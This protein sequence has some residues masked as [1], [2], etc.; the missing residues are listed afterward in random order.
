M[1]IRHPRLELW[2]HM[3]TQERLRPHQPT[4]IM[5]HTHGPLRS[6]I[7]S[8]P[9]CSEHGLVLQIR[10]HDHN[11]RGRLCL[12]AK[13]T[14]PGHVL[15]GHEG[16]VCDDDHVEVPIRNEHAIR[17]F[18]DLGEDVLDWIRR[19]VAFAFGAAVVVAA[20]FN[21][22]DEDGVVGAFAPGDVRGRMDGGFDVGAVEVGGSAVGSVDELGGEGEDVPE[23]RALLVHFV[24]V[25]AGVVC[26]GGQ[27]DLVEDIAVGFASVV[28]EDG[29][30]VTGRWEGEV[31]FSEIGVSAGF[32]ETFKLG[33]E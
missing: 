25:E 19:E 29:C 10:L 33:E 22:A 18:D 6:V 16:A 2:L 14:I 5:L 12:E 32:V 8:S 15:N 27:V 3:P 7:S 30:L 24:D 23:K 31:L 26:Q 21:T 4:L 17:G 11:W 20:Y 13:L 1:P 28:E 9:V